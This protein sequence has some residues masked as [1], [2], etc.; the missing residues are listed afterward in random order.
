MLILFSLPASS[1]NKMDLKIIQVL[2]RFYVSEINEA[3]QLYESLFDTKCSLRFYYEETGLELAQI[4]N[5]LL[6]AGSEEA[7]KPYRETKAT[8]IVNTL[9]GF[10]EYLLVNG[11]KIIRDI[12]IVPTGKNMTLKHPDGTIIEYVQFCDWDFSNNSIIRESPP[13]DYQE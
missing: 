9:E 11:S 1:Q 12:K 10:K 3:I 7:L 2:N 8:F 13:E 6:L 5:V 4:G